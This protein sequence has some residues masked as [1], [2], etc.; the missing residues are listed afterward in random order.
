MTTTA[1][2]T[3]SCACG[4]VRFVAEG[5]PYRVGLCHCFD[6]RKQ[7]GTPFGAFVIFPADRVTFAGDEPGVFATSAAYRHHFC[8]T[9][10]SPVFSRDEGSDEVELFLGSFDEVNRFAP[11]YEVWTTRREAWLS[12]IPGIVNRYEQNRVGSQR[13]EL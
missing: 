10:G 6:C 4:A 7:H 2:S 8:R 11:T 13:T 5:E 3:G 1:R 9:C 12:A